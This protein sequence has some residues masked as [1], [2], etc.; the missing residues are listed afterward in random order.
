MIIFETLYGGHVLLHYFM[1]SCFSFVFLLH[2][3]R[4]ISGNTY[5]VL[6]KLYI[7]HLQI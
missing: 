6:E 5:T 2:K 4:A 7:F 1:M 3:I